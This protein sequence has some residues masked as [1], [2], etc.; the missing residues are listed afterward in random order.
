MSERIKRDLWRC[1][2]G[3]V[4]RGH[5]L[6]VQRISLKD[7][8]LEIVCLYCGHP[9]VAG[10]PGIVNQVASVCLDYGAKV[11]QPNSSNT[12]IKVH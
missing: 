5:H 1:V 10:S 2:R 9:L 11:F 12:S 8:D 4:Q 3:H 6:R 7:D